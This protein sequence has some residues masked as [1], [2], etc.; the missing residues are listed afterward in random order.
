M[1]EDSC[2]EIQPPDG[3]FRTPLFLIHDGG[4]TI[5]SYYMLEELDR[6]LYG[7]SNPHF[8]TGE[9]F[10]GGMAEIADLYISY[11]REK[12]YSGEILIGGWSLGGMIALE[13]AHRMADDDKIGVKG[14]VFVDSPYPKTQAPADLQI[15]SSGANFAPITKQD[16]RDKIIRCMENSRN[17][18]ASWNLPVWK[19]GLSPPP[20]VL[21]RSR[22][23]VYPL[24]SGKVAR[25]DFARDDKYLGWKEY[26]PDLI[27]H[28]FDIDG[29]HYDA[30]KF[31]YLE[32]VSEKIKS[33]C[34]ML[35]I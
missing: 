12:Y 8:D 33:A 29:P 27:K 28:T 2:V 4:G 35:D 23:R 5:F 34:S 32:N 11:I 21:L 30:F 20:T 18:I 26:H 1:E 19:Q 16:V 25:V 7:I 13:I 10:S 3:P 17:M 14:M 24:E 22:E 6:P 31:D 15:A 9:P